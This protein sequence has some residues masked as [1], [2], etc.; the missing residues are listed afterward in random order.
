[1]WSVGYAVAPTLF[2]SLGDKQLTGE[3]AGHLFVVSG[4]I[5]GVSAL[6]LMIFML[7]R[8]GVSAFKRGVFWLLLMMLVLTL[9]SQFGVQPFIARLKAEALPREVM[10]SVLRDRFAAWHGIASMLYLLQSIL[11]IVLVLKAE[12][13]KN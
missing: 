13:A 10:E 4:W 1:M 2:Y 6:F 11:G 8:Q 12:R 7:V 5:G 3:I 9:A